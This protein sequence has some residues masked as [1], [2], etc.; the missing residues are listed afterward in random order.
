[1]LD[2]IILIEIGN[3]SIELQTKKSPFS[4]TK[5]KYMWQI[6]VKQKTNFKLEE[7]AFDVNMGNR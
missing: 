2:S 4:K 7:V 5:K 3:R 6:F 1:M